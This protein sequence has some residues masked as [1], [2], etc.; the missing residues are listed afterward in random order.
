MSVLAGTEVMLA[1]HRP[2]LF[3]EVGPAGLTQFDSGAHAL[4]AFLARFGYIP[5]ALERDGAKPLTLPQLDSL[6]AERGYV[7]L[8]FIANSA[9]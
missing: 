1:R 8:L 5:H 2:V 6:L 4:L 7:D 9:S 3:I